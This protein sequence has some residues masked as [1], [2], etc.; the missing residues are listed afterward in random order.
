[1]I[2][3][4]PRIGTAFFLSLMLAAALKDD[5][6]GLLESTYWAD[7]SIHPTLSLI[8]EHSIYFLLIATILGL[9]IFAK[10]VN[11]SLR[12]TSASVFVLILAFAPILRASYLDTAIIHKFIQAFSLT[13]FIVLVGWRITSSHGALALKQELS[14]AFYWLSVILITAN[15]LNMAFGHGFAPNNSRLFGTTT[16]PNFLGV[17]LAICNIAISSRVFELSFSQWKQYIAQAMLLLSGLFMLLLTGS[18][19][20]FLVMLVGISTLWLARKGFRVSFL[21][22]LALTILVATFVFFAIYADADSTFYRGENG[23]NTRSS[24]WSS[25][26]DLIKERPWIG[27]GRFIGQSENSFL[28]SMIAFGIP[29][30]L[31]LFATIIYSL[32]RLYRLSWKYRTEHTSPEHLHFSLLTALITGAVFEGYLIDSWSLPRLTFIILAL[33]CLSR[34]SSSSHYPNQSN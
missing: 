27:H 28:R 1:M 2:A 26:L 4:K 34:R 17:Q 16:H 6:E 24:A 8:K 22:I 3:S 15:F 10:N 29:Y 25:M 11:F 9:F 12:I 31:L 30:G 20:G 19:T 23:V 13:F 33:A 21:T 5:A 32:V 18:R 7:L 14:N